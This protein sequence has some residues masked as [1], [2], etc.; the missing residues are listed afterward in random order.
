MEDERP[1][2]III[3]DEIP[4]QQPKDDFTQSMEINMPQNPKDP[5]KEH[6]SEIQEQLKKGKKKKK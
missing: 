1:T 5:L 4:K 6:P 3:E 2:E